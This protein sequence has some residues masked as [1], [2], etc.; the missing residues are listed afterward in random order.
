MVAINKVYKHPK[1]NRKVHEILKQVNRSD[2]KDLRQK[3]YAQ[4]RQHQTNKVFIGETH[5]II[6][7]RG[8][9]VQKGIKFFNIT[10]FN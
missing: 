5:C 4:K 7:A 3:N 9:N 6:Q 2:N 8:S 10:N 1:T